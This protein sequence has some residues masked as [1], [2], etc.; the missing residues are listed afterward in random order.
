M[1]LGIAP[2]SY[3][4]FFARPGGM[5]VDRRSFAYNYMGA[6]RP[7]FLST[8]LHVSDATP[9]DPAEWLIERCR[10]AEVPVAHCSIVRWDDRAH[11][12]RV[13]RMLNEYRIEMVPSIS[14]DMVCRG[15]PARQAQAI[16]VETIA[17]Y[18]DFGGV[19]ISKLCTPMTYH[20]FNR[21]VRVDE[22]LALIK[23]NVRP[24]VRAAEE[25]GIVLA[26]ENHYDYRAAEVRGILDDVGSPNL[27]SLFDVGSPFAVCEEPVEAAKILAPYT[28]FVHLKDCLIQPWT[29]SST[30]GPY[31]CQYAV[32]LGEG[33]VD[34]PKIAAILNEQAPAPKSLC[35][36]VE[37]V[38]VPAQQDEDRWVAHA[39]EWSRT[40]LAQYLS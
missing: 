19:R 30:A 10:R 26:F 16:A 38:P 34:I 18:R 15:E 37:T 11:L 3:Q 33:N 29:P 35:L 14:V 20:R 31:A 22:Q 7:Y 21:Q 6:E 8:P 23:A 24:V 1:R 9:S 13:R 39:I 12:D 32:P 5:F 4:W 2:A 25:A 40:N 17:R 36:A 27:R 28:V